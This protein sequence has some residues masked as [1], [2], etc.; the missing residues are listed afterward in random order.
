MQNCDNPNC[1]FYDYINNAI[2]IE[3]EKHKFKFGEKN[4]PKFSFGQKNSHLKWNLANKKA[5]VRIWKRNWG[6]TLSPLY[7]F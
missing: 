7:A 6:Y 1:P 5:W 3:K 2:E 4:K